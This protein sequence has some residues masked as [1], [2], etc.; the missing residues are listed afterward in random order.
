MSIIEVQSVS[1]SYPDSL[2]R[3]LNELSLS[4]QEGDFVGIVGPSGA[5]KSTLTGERQV[6]PPPLLSACS[7]HDMSSSQKRKLQ[8]KKNTI[9]L[10]GCVKK[11]IKKQIRNCERYA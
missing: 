10:P 11:Y 5:G 7:A 4:V 3:A 9:T 6:V 8:C 1:Y 2:A